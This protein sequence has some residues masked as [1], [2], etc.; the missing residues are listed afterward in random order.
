[1]KDQKETEF[2]KVKVVVNCEEESRISRKNLKMYG[3]IKISKLF[4]MAL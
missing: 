1:M 3:G 2:G 4:G